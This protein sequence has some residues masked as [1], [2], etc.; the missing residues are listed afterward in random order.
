VKLAQSPS[1]KTLSS[2]FVCSDDHKA[3]LGSGIHVAYG[4]APDR[5]IE[6]LRLAD[7]IHEIAMPAHS[8]RAEV[9]GVTSD[10]KNERVV[11]DRPA[12]QHAMA[13]RQRDG[14]ELDHLAL[15]IETAKLAGPVVQSIAL[16]QGRE[17][18]ALGAVIGGTGREHVVHRIPDMREL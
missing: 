10:R 7:V 15:A 6:R 3:G 2:S 9:V 1:A 17:A 11:R 8:R 4:L 18:E 5:G 13:I 16:G 12:G 14:P